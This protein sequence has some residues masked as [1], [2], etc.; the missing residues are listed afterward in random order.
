MHNFQDIF[1]IDSLPDSCDS[2]VDRP[3]FNIIAIWDC[4]N[5]Q[6]GI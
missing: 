4:K 5:I 3:S 1:S 2:L 6:Q